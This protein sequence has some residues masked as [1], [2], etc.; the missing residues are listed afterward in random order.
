MRLALSASV[1]F[2]IEDPEV[3]VTLMVEPSLEGTTHRIL[4]ESLKTTP[5]RAAVLDRDAMGNPI[6]RF[7]V[8][9]GMF[10]FDFR[11]VAELDPAPQ[12]PWDAPAPRLFDLAAEELRYLYPSRYC[13]S[14]DL[15]R[16]AATEF[17]GVAPGG[18]RVR[19]IVEWV[20]ARVELLSVAQRG[21]VTAAHTALHRVG[22][23]GDLAHL[24][25]AL[26]RA[27]EIP[28][29]YVSGYCF[30]YDREEF[31]CWAEVWLSGTWHP[32]DPT[33]AA[34]QRAGL[35]PIAVGRD[36]ADVRPIRLYGR[37]HAREQSVRVSPVTDEDV[38]GVP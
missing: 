33:T 21:G 26:S 35:V 38:A 36:A 15:R 16:M 23:D 7:V 10:S 22:G 29:R 24:V 30:G 4:H 3:F 8:P 28:A 25:I 1:D 37:G 19:R 34:D 20:R 2:E 31:H 9:R 17:G 5:V 6:R 11:A 18:E 13:E 32:V 27:M 12:L 14:D